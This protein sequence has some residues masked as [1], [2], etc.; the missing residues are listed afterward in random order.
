MFLDTF[1]YQCSLVC[2]NVFCLFENVCIKLQVGSIV[3]VVV[4]IIIVFS[5]V[6]FP[7][8]ACLRKRSLGDARA[9]TRAAKNP[10][11]H[12]STTV[13]IDCLSPSSSFILRTAMLHQSTRAHVP[14]FCVRCAWCCGQAASH[15]MLRRRRCE[16][17]AATRCAGKSETSCTAK[18]YHA[19]CR[20]CAAHRSRSCPHATPGQVCHLPS[21]R[22]ARVARQAG[23]ALKVHHPCC[24][25]TAR[26]THSG[27]PLRIQGAHR[28]PDRVSAV[29]IGCG[30]VATGHTWNRAVVPE[31]R[32][33]HAPPCCICNGTIADGARSGVHRD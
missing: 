13:L 16:C 32:T 33:L 19:R 30:Y 26:V 7:L 17:Q 1:Q 15:C 20:V 18:P 8:N 25:C 9:S 2:F 3:W 27:R 12:Q 31:V 5:K 22:G 23:Q 6:T 4:F 28:A 24:T 10:F 11:A 29:A 21:M 14:M